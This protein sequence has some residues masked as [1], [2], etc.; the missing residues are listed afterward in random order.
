MAE[1]AF[2]FIGT[3]L[4]FRL[5]LNIPYT[6]LLPQPGAILT[7]DLRR[8]GGKEIE[9]AAWTPNRPLSFPPQVSILR[10]VVIVESLAA[11]GNLGL[12]LAMTK[13]Y[14]VRESRKAI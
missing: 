9:A 6:S 14:L 8:W 2:S 10:V 7:N 1:E 5:S 3:V 4:M 12:L 11:E 13:V